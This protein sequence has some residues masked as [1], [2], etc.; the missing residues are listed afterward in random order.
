MTGF[1]REDTVGLCL[2][3]CGNGKLRKNGKC[4]CP[5][6]NKEIN[7]ECTKCPQYTQYVNGVCLCYNG[8]L[9]YFGRCQFLSCPDRNQVWDP[10][11]N[12][13][14]CKKPLSWL[15]GQCRYIE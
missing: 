2:P 4:Q 13:C 14:K 10:I 5:G 8:K 11:F 12:V 9:P 3:E 15:F 7:G 1:A 6:G